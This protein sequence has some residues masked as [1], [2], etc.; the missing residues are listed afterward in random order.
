M[1][2]IFLSLVLVLGALSLVNAQDRAIGLK[3]GDGTDIS[4][5]QMLG[6]SNRLELNLGLYGF[7]S[8]LYTVSGIY[9]WVWDLSQLSPGFKWYA[10]VGAQVGFFNYSSVSKFYTWVIGNV[11]IEYNFSNLPLQ[12]ALDVTPAIRLIPSGKEYGD[13]FYATEGLRLAV[14][15]KF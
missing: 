1:K 12:L 15:Y 3:F 9:Q 10:G 7:D 13:A 8:H 11:G 14:R 2:R 4:Y 6:S 5:Q